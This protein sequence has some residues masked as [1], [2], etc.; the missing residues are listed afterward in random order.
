MP[1]RLKS[2]VIP[3]AMSL[4]RSSCLYRITYPQNVVTLSCQATA[5]TVVNRSA[6]SAS[7]ILDNKKKFRV[8]TH[9]CVFVSVLT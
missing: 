7:L 3:L 6:N 2:E 9:C 4:K 8:K 5:Q 1:P